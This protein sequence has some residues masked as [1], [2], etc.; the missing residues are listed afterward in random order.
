MAFQILG[1]NRPRRLRLPVATAPA[2][3]EPNTKA[4]QPA[5]SRKPPKREMQ[6]AVRTSPV[7]AKAVAADNRA[8]IME[9][10]HA[11]K[12]KHPDMLL[13]FRMGD[14]YELFGQD[15]ELAHKL[16]GLTLTTRDRTLTM[17]G[18]PHHQLEIYLHS[19][20][21]RGNASPSANRWRSRWPAGQFAA[22]SRA[23]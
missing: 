16:L 21:T 4:P 17:A 9:Q 6:P 1:P 13:L 2:E 20:S 3:I 5:K 22:K 7:N 15:A 8:T 19:C 14:F 18:F 11:A 12:E 10:Y 23:S